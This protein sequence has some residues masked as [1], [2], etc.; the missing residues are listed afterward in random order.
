MGSAVRA[1]NYTKRFLLEKAKMFKVAP[2]HVT[3]DVAAQILKELGCGEDPIK[4]LSKHD[5]YDVENR[6]EDSQTLEN[7]IVCYYPFSCRD[8]CNSIKL[9]YYSNGKYVKGNLWTMLVDRLFNS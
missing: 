1:P 3:P 4:L 5:W 8:T 6:Y 7:T 9:S 2:K